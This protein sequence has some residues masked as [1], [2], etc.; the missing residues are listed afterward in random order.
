M[1]LNP[2][3]YANRRRHPL[4][5]RQLANE[6]RLHHEPIRLAFIKGMMPVHE[7]VALDLARRCLKE[8]DSF[9]TILV[10]GLC[11]AN[12]SSMQYY[13]KAVFDALGER[14]LLRLLDKH[15]A[16]YPVGVERAAYHLHGLYHHACDAAP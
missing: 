5:E 6:L 7:V 11:F 2:S 12:A 16:T 1:T 10:I 14:R 15:K 4:W 3:D 8:R 9:E 13:L